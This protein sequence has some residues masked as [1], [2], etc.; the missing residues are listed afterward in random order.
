MTRIL[1]L[2]DVEVTGVEHDPTAGT[3]TLHGRVCSGVVACPTCGAQTLTLHQYH[4]RP[5]RDLPWAGH[6]TV[7]LL[8]RRR[9]RCAACAQVF[10][11]P[12]AAVAPRA[13]TTRRFAAA[14]VAACRDTSLAA[15]A[16]QHAVGYKLVEGLY[17]ATAATHHPVGPPRGAVRV[18]GLDEIAM[19]K[20]RGDFKLVVVNGE[21][22]AVLDQLPARDKAT[23]AAYFAAW[24]PQQR[25]AVEEVTADF[26]APYHDLAAAYFPQAR[27]TG[28]RF[29]VQKAVN[30]ALNQTRIA[31]RRGRATAARAE[32][33]ELRSRLLRN[34]ADLDATDRAWVQAAGQAYPALGVAY[35]LKE[36]LRRMYEAAPTRRAAACRLGW[37]V[38]KA[39][40]SGLTAFTK[41]ADFMDT[42]WE[43]I[44]NY[45][46][47]RRSNGVVEGCNNKI[48]L[49]KRRGYGFTN[50]SHFRLRVL[51]ECD[52]T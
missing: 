5:V 12:C 51:M 31:E 26:W 38:K 32:L 22:G 9:W 30:R 25:A 1:A 34:G 14:L 16:R 4:R 43:T 7:L 39:R 48:K 37:W 11:E 6:R 21:T 27:R 15:V 17:Y 47:E 42:W 52:G 40:T 18:L 46:V 13:T 19:R 29:H 41:L 3:L 2:P 8:T 23:V 49:I 33:A 50:D 10:L 36:R 35:E 45:F 24:S 44:L 20:G 28:D